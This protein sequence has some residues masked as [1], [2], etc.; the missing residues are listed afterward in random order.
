VSYVIKAM[1]ATNG[2]LSSQC[3]ESSKAVA[4]FQTES[5]KIILLQGSDS[6]MVRRKRWLGVS[7]I[8]SKYIL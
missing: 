1:G 6:Q 7:R 2:K 4:K 3:A 5:L 8:L